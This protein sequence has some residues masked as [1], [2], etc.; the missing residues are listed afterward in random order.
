MS[1]IIDANGALV[2]TQARDSGDLETIYSLHGT[3]GVH[4]PRSVY[5]L[6]SDR[7]L[8]NAIFIDFFWVG[9]GVMLMSNGGLTQIRGTKLQKSQNNEN[10]AWNHQVDYRGGTILQLI[11]AQSHGRL[12]VG[13]MV[14]GHI[15]ILREPGGASGWIRLSVEDGIWAGALHL[16]TTVQYVFPMMTN[17]G[18]YEMGIDITGIRTQ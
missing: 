5:N 7:P 8:W 17:A 9:N 1:N 6:L 11:E 2:A 14:H 12:D 16:D 3:D 13:Y 10:R 15:A 4:N 18:S